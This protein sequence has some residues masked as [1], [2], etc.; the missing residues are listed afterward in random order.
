VGLCALLVA[1]GAIGILAFRAG[2]HSVNAVTALTGSAYSNGRSEATIDAGGWNYGVSYGVSWIGPDG[3][4]N[5]GSWPVCLPRGTSE[6][7]FGWVDTTHTTGQRT[8]VWVRC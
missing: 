5:D 1:C 8:V 4:I 3:T 6:V 7:T 2:Q